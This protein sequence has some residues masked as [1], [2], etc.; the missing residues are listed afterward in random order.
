MKT[1]QVTRSHNDSGN[2]REYFRTKPNNQLICLQQEG[3]NSGVW[4]TCI[5]DGC[6]EEPCS[7][8]DTSKYYIEVVES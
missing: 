7:Q 6:W 2:C 1:V 5:D 4:Y 3:G 8:I